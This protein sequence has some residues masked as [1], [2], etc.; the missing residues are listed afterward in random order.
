M[1]LGRTQISDY[2]QRRDRIV[3]QKGNKRRHL[4]ILTLHC[5]ISCFSPKS[6]IYFFFPDVKPSNILVNSRGEIKLCDFG[7]SGQLIDSMANSFVGT[8]SYMS[9]STD[10]SPDSTALTLLGLSFLSSGDQTR[11]SCCCSWFSSPCIPGIFW[12]HIRLCVWGKNCCK[13]KQKL[14]IFVTF[15]KSWGCVCTAEPSQTLPLGVVHVCLPEN[16]S[17]HGLF[18][19]GSVVL[20]PLQHLLGCS[21][22]CG[23][24]PT[25]LHGCS[26]RGNPGS[27]PGINVG[28]FAGCAGGEEHLGISS[29]M[30]S[31]FSHTLFCTQLTA[32]LVPSSGCAINTVWV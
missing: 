10:F 17:V 5:Q 7:V 32:A 27:G 3:S 12:C 2:S 1:D 31:L 8:R 16:P 6:W 23:T 28:L 29:Q 20:F 21:V 15:Q 22:G 25:S 30:S 26:N 9:V 24:A 18:S 19:L 13:K 11:T 14:G 4:R